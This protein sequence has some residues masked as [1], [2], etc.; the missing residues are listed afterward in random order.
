MQ[1]ASPPSPESNGDSPA[2]RHGSDRQ[3]QKQQQYTYTRLRPRDPQLPPRVE[4]VLLEE[5]GRARDLIARS[6]NLPSTYAADLVE[7]GAVYFSPSVPPLPPDAAPHVV[8]A[9]SLALARGG[10]PGAP[11]GTLSSSTA[12]A[13]STGSS[14]LQP[15][16]VLSHP[17]G[18]SLRAGGPTTLAAAEGASP[19]GHLSA[20]CPLPGEDL[21]SAAGVCGEGNAASGLDHAV[22]ALPG[23][24]RGQEPR[25]P[26]RLLDP[27]QELPAGGYMRVHVHPRR[28]PRCHEID[29]SSRICLDGPDFVVINKPAGVSVGGTVDNRVE[30]CTAL[31]ARALGLKEPLRITHQVDQCTQGCVVLAKTREFA[32]AFNRRLQEKRVRKVYRAL[33]VGA[34]ATGR[35][36][37]YMR[38]D[39][40]PPRIISQEPIEGWLRC[41]LEVLECRQ[42]AWPSAAAAER[43]CVRSPGWAAQC[44][45]YECKIHLLTGRTHQV[46][47][48]LGA[49]GAPLVGDTMYLPAVLTSG[50][51]RSLAVS[52]EMVDRSD[53]ME[54]WKKSHGREPE[55]AIG[56]HA[57]EITWDDMFGMVEGGSPWWG[58]T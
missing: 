14:P 25:R 58:E 34:A 18:T 52:Q 3:R 55:G 26:S 45:A 32:A 37:H 6:L 31:A 49:L 43:E 50:V 53:V 27:D 40:F 4:H 41:E 15:L 39:R 7:F 20:T 8:A 21:G 35:H 11:P 51:R 9:Y 48:Q 38:P 5:P 17:H 24:R 13:A 16:P 42:V 10:A 36:V 46:R 19:G 23:R 12:S 29:W 30:A 2:L 54:G 56:L 33:A 28:F 47:T 1:L 44:H 57:S 22:D